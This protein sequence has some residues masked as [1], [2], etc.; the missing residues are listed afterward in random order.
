MTAA[1]ADCFT[2][3]EEE[4]LWAPL[5]QYSDYHKEG[6]VQF[7]LKVPHL[8]QVL[9]T[10]SLDNVDTF[11]IPFYSLFAWEGTISFL[12]ASETIF[13]VSS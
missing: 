9:G 3:M 8:F 7:F 10:Q 2:E 12:S 6:W 5:A 11:K 1:K 4:K 13:L